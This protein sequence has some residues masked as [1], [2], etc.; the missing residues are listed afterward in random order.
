MAIINLTAL[1]S[2]L[3]SNLPYTSLALLFCVAYVAVYRIYFS[4]LAHVPGPKLAA[5]SSLYEFYHDCIRLGQ[6]V[7]RLDELHKQYGPI[8]RIGPSEVHIKDAQFFDKFYNVTTKLD[9]YDWFYRFANTPYASFGTIKAEDH[10]LRRSALAKHFSPASIIRLDPVITQAV[11]ILCR[12]LE[13]HRR[14]KRVVDLG[15]AFRCFSGDVVTEYVV[16]D[17]LTL[18]EHENFAADYNSVFIRRFAIFGTFNRHLGWLLPV[19]LSMPRWLLLLTNPPAVLQ[20]FSR[21]K[22]IEEQARIVTQS[23]G[24]PKQKKN[25]PLVLSSIYHSDLP[26]HEKTLI[27]LAQDGLVLVMA[28]TETTAITLSVATYHLLTKPHLLKRLQIE[29]QSSFPAAADDTIISYRDL[30]KLPFLTACLNESLRLGSPVS[31]RLPRIDPNSP[32]T[33]GDHTLPAGTAISMTLRDI[34]Y[35]PSIYPDPRSFNPDRWLED[36]DRARKLHEHFLVPF[37]KGARSCIGNNLA[38][39]GMYAI[40]GNMFRKFEAIELFETTAD[41]FE[42]AYDFFSPFAKS[43][44]KGLRVLIK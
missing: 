40:L 1:F 29:L 7:F 6:F 39:A 32:I 26:A 8:V 16:P 15:N 21:I 33:Y 30:E 31:G 19:M 3:V 23:G 20:V 38:L 37:G 13:E 4:P 44:S 2:R 36:T 28:G 17:P 10:R 43:D 41:D 35:D 9:K 34:H 18:L 42:M 11:S 12:R 24:P 22:L 5:V 25:Y 27:R 14:G